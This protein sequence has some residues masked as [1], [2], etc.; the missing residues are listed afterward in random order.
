MDIINN[1]CAKKHVYMQVEYQFLYRDITLLTLSNY[2]VSII[3]LLVVM[4]DCGCYSFKYICINLYLLLHLYRTDFAMCQFS[5]N[6]VDA[7][8]F[9]PYLFLFLFT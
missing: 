4:F 6:C 3:D 2:A 9:K 1:F 8:W 5:M 7:V